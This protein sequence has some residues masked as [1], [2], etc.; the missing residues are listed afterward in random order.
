MQSVANNVGGAGGG[1]GYQGIPSSV[2]V[3]FDSWNNGSIDGF[4]SN[5]AGIDVNGNVN[6]VVRAEITAADL[7]DGDI[8]NAWV[9]YDG[10]THILEA[11]LS[12]SNVRPSAPFLSHT[13]DL[14]STLG[15]TDVYAGF[16][17]GTGSAFADHDVLLWVLDN[18][19][20]PIN[21]VLV[22]A[23]AYLFGAGLVGLAGLARRRSD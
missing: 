15:S 23:A 9:D 22:P 19:Y 1:I 5:H 6:S 21:P 11:R 14:A 10:T 4:S 7:N 8:W 12:L 2:A 17:S 13:I 16:T 20:S 3:E 18:S